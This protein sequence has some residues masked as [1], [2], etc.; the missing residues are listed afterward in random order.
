M[1][2]GEGDSEDRTED[3]TSK[4]R[5]QA[6]EKGQ[7]P[8]SRDLNTM[9]LLLAMSACL[10]VGGSHISAGMAAI[11][12]AGFVI[13]RE[14]L[15]DPNSMVLL[16]EQAVFNALLTVGPFLLITV[17]VA[18][19]APILNGSWVFS[20]S[21]LGFNWGRI[22]PVAGL[23]RLF[24]LHGVMEM[25]K[26]LLKF[27]VLIAVAYV[28]IRTQMGSVLHLVT[29][30]VATGIAQSGSLL[31]RDLLIFSAVTIIIAAADVPYQYWSHARKL[32]MSKQEV[33]DEMKETEG[34][35]EIKSRIRRLQQD[36]ARRRMMQAVPKADVIITNPTHY[37]VALRY[38]ATRMRA[39]RV[40]AKGADELAL[41][42]REVGT[43]HRVPVVTA[44]PL[45]RA[46]YYSTRLEAEIPEG[47]Y[48]AVA[49]VLAYVMQLKRT[50]TVNAEDLS[51]L[52]IPSELRRDV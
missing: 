30:P 26:A 37:A 29:L 38:E 15:F 28:I 34:R 49:Q 3:A 9:F 11:F 4:R 18:L 25:L 50:G 36:A 13:E 24:G 12:T 20:W 43:A 16:L 5:S 51:E 31:S 39:P 21:A 46:I 47:L 23:K 19:V 41:K 27:S 44:P 14:A 33:K 45:A 2:E 32:K 35:P 6:R 17:V 40:V 10:Y 22:N 52:P 48:V 42:I 1:A 7:T 8:R